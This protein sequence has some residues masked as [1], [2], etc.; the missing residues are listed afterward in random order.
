MVQVIVQVMVQITN[1]IAILQ[2]LVDNWRIQVEKMMENDG[3]TDDT[4]DR[5]SRS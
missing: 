1:Q 5:K 3:E 2:F 4:L